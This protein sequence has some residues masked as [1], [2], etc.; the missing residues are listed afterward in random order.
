MKIT[1]ALACLVFVARSAIASP[2]PKRKVIVLEF[3]SGSSALAGIGNRIVSTLAKQTSLQVL[4]PD[5]VRATYGDHLDEA[6]SRCSG[7]ATCIS[8]IGARVGASEILLVGVSELGDVILTM[9]R[10][11]VPTHSVMARIAD[12][13][14]T[15]STPDEDKLSYYLARL[16]PPS[17]F[18][19]FGVIDII[20]SQAGA[21][22]TIDKEPRGKTPIPP[23]R[24]HAPASYA[25]RVEKKG[26]TPF[27]TSIDLPPDGTLKVEANLTHT[28]HTAWY[29]H[30]YVLTI[31]AIIVAAAAGG[32]IYYFTRPGESSTVPVIVS[33]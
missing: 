1:A 9:Q 8:R 5:Q 7:D 29:A 33:Y 10:I 19:R 18:L 14:P 25:I 24:L 30:W 16:L 4:G 3:R 12:S 21:L 17:D 23:L 11:Q 6:I 32:A 22:V 27:E 26:F 13:L 28:S 31:G 15:G 20:S 2:D